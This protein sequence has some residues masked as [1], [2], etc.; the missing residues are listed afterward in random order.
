MNFDST[1]NFGKKVKITIP[2]RGSWTPP[3]YF[4]V[5]L[6]PILVNPDAFILK[7]HIVAKHY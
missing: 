5:E 2:R 4:H 3:K 6:P 1:P 7:K